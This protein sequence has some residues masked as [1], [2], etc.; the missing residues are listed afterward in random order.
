M[1]PRRPS[2]LGRRPPPGRCGSEPGPLQPTLQGAHDGQGLVGELAS[3]HHADQ[4]RTPAWVGAAQV[5]SRLHEGFRRF[6]CRGPTTAIGGHHR[7]LSLLTEALNQRADGA[8]GEAQCHGD[9][10]A[11]L[12]VVEAPPDGL[13]YGYRDGTR[14]GMSSDRDEVRRAVP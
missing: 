13:A 2:A 4:T 7:G 11:I 6:R 5:Q 12:T 1:G 3:Q 14:H 9:G 8:W 10:G